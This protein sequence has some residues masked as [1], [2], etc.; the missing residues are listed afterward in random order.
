MNDPKQYSYCTAFKNLSSS[1][2]IANTQQTNASTNYSGDAK[3]KNDNTNTSYGNSNNQSSFST[4][5]PPSS[6]SSNSGANT[7]QFSTHTTYHKSTGHHKGKHGS[8]HRGS[9]QQTS[10]NGEKIPVWTPNGNA[11]TNGLANSIDS[12]KQIATGYGPVPGQYNL[13]DSSD[14]QQYNSANNHSSN[15]SSN[16]TNNQQYNSI[17]KNYSK[18]Q[19]GLFKKHDYSHSEYSSGANHSA[20]NTGNYSYKVTISMLLNGKNNA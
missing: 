9:H 20:Y 5:S 12:G 6:S 1:T 7:Q 4:S 18:Q 3:Q 11:N 16:L 19:Y 8:K 17:N 15:G 13:H 10:G 2:N 14:A